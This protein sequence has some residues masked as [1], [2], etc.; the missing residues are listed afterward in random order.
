[1]PPWSFI[2]LLHNL[3][4]KE[5]IGNEYVAIV[6]DTDQRAKELFNIS[7]SLKRLV[8]GF[9]DQFGRK[10]AP[11]LLLVHPESP[12][13]VLEQDSLIAFRN[14]LAICSVV[15]AWQESL[16][17][18]LSLNVLKYSNYFDLY[19]ITVG[20]EDDVL[21]IRSPSILGMDEPDEFVGQTSPELAPSH[22]VFRFF[23]VELHEAILKLW[24]DKFILAN[25]TDWRS[26]VLFRSLEMAY[27]ASSIPFE[28]S[29]TIYDYG[30]KLALWISAFEV[31]VRSEN[32]Q[33]SLSKALQLL[34]EAKIYS[35]HLRQHRY[36][37]V[38]S[39]KNKRRGT[40][41]Q[42]IYLSMHKARNNFLHGNPVGIRDLFIKKLLGFH[43]LTS[44]APILYKQALQSFL[45]VSRHKDISGYDYGQFA[46]IR[47]FEEALSALGMKRP[48]KRI[49][50]HSKRH[51]TRRHNQKM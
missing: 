21:L 25:N 3:S 7:S 24:H 49:G 47:N 26:R 28:N 39:E 27:H 23:D 17:R 43:P 18:K 46:D 8:E 45:Q 12:K 13:G 50:K 20:K 5:P 29:S 34:D 10:V 48:S 33:A 11:S 51:S 16:V 22:R 14:A 30:A 2:A 15:H 44:G 32:E 4:L 36:T 42:Q 31:L 38:F 1:M 40:L 35:R 37:L 19:P 6:P 9:T 41:S